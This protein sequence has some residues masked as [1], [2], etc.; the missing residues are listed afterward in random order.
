MNWDALMVGAAFLGG[1]GVA[2]IS[3]RYVLTETRK[4]IGDLKLEIV[5]DR[6]IFIEKLNGKYVNRRLCDERHKRHNHETV[7]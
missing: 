5:K 2:G 7:D 3:A 4:S 1:S 6:E